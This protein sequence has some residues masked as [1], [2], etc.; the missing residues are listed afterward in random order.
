MTPVSAMPSALKARKVGSVFDG[1]LLM[2]EE[3]LKGQPG[4][5]LLTAKERELCT[6]L[7]LVPKQYMLMKDV[8][9][10]ESFRLNVLSK[11]SACKLLEN[12]G[13]FLLCFG[14]FV[15]F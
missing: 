9:I 8:L 13:T 12:F 15:T 14:S 11:A 6:A 4:V 10:R 1:N 2:S 7:S 5:E 3:D